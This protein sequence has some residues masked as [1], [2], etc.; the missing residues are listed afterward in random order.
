MV[1]ILISNVF[2]TSGWCASLASLTLF[3]SVVGKN[4]KVFVNKYRCWEKARLDHFF[5][6]PIG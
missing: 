3:L 4:A 5:W 2:L 1:Q 6:C